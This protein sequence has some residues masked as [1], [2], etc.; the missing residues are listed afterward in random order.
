M[1][2][3][4][5]AKRSPGPRVSMRWWEQEG[6]DLEGVRMATREAEQ[7]EREED[8]DGTDIATDN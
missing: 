6:L 7:T 1:D 2:L 8:T 4:L 3:C 5:A